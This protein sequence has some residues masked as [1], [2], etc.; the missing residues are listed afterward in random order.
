MTDA[1]S[2]NPQPRQ[3]VSCPRCHERFSLRLDDPACPECGHADDSRPHAE[4][5]GR[6]PDAAA[7]SPISD[8]PE[9]SVIGSI[10]NETQPQVTM[11]SLEGQTLVIDPG[12]RQAY[13]SQRGTVRGDA[14]AFFPD[15]FEDRL[16]KRLHIY[17]LERFLGAGGMGRVYLARHDR[18]D[19]RCAVKVLSP[20]AAQTDVDF[21]RRFQQEGQ[22]A[23]ALLHPNVVVTHAIGEEREFHFLEMEY[24][25]GGSLTRLVQDEGP[26]S[27]V[28]ATNL[29]ARVADGLAFAHRRGIVHRDLKTDNVMMTLGGVPKISD[30][31][32]AKRIHIPDPDEESYLAGTPPYM[33]P[34]L[35]TGSPASPASDVYALG[36]VY[37]VLLTGRLPY[38][39]ENLPALRQK[40]LNDPPPNARALVPELPLEMAECLAQML[41]KCPTNRPPHGAAASQLLQAVAGQLR[42]LESLLAEAFQDRQD[43][44]WSK[45]GER[46]TVRVNF[47]DGRKQDV[48]LDPDGTAAADRRLRISSVCG[49]ASPHYYEQ[50]LRL[51][52]RNPSRQP[53]DLRP[54]RHTNVLRHRLL[55]PRHRRP[56]RNPPHRPRTR[57]PRRRPRTPPDRRRPVLSG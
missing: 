49:P 14:G 25:S 33:A 8:R 55:P 6:V 21:I 1:T 4:F 30:F 56:G 22:A 38:L 44:S 10:L 5:A 34:E 52:R 27:P 26:L 48:F 13:W 18:L 32:L 12:G 3:T 47:R 24:V 40:V 31:G 42:D 51:K 50:A 39:A 29:V 7:Q 41:D 2:T 15:N 28:R 11:D 37:F 35:F 54:R 20:K 19:R 9:L 45:A 53:D 57:P 46:Y 16:G 23:A 17:S 43:V 36:V